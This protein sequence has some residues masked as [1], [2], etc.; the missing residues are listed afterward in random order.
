MEP[1][2]LTGEAR[3]TSWRVFALVLFS[4][5][6]FFQSSG[7][8]EAA[9]FDQMRSLTEHGEWWIDRYAGNTA[10]VVSVGG[11]T[12]PD[13]SPGTTLLGALPWALSRALFS[14]L[15]IDEGKQLI[16]VTYAL[17][18]LMSALPTALTAL[19]MFRFLAR[20]A[21]TIAQATL[22]SLGYGLGTIAFPFAT[23]FFG[24]QLAAFFAFSGFYLVWSCRSITGRPRA[25]RLILS[26]LM[27]GFLPVIENPGA[28][29]SVP[30][31][32]MQS[33]TMVLPR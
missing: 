5:A 30:V 3:V 9:R 8:N 27:I 4:A 14:L 31:I 28:I 21:W 12:Y 26:G 25:L 17:T 18:V 33:G 19:L 23:L 2:P 6:Y 13:K 29:A 11:H 1:T 15:P 24:H 7:H 10:D 16:L 20:N 22:L 32:R